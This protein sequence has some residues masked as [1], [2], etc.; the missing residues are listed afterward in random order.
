MSLDFI[1]EIRHNPRSLVFAF[2]DTLFIDA[3]LTECE[4]ILQGDHFALQTDEFTDFCHLP[5]AI[6]HPLH[7]DDQVDGGRYLF[8]D[9]A[10]RQFDAGHHHHRLQAGK[11]VPWCVRVD[12]RQG[13]VMPC[14]H[15]LQ[16][17]Q[18]FPAA[19]LPDNDAIRAHPQA[20]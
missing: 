14:I 1:Q 15:R 19:Y 18:C 11:A 6:D 9:C 17:I 2:H 4:Y 3:I 20:N 7:L 5:A 16:H 13:T 10:R 8:P 12:C